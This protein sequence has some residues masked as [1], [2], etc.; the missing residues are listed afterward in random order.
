LSV[1][2]ID[3][4]ELAAFFGLSTVAQYPRLQ[5]ERAVELLMEEL[6]PRGGDDLD[7]ENTPLPFDLI[8]RSTT[9]RPHRR[10]S[11]TR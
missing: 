11:A 3:D 8:V 4:H 1:I 7:D 6:Q 9:A 2:G 5:G 10:S